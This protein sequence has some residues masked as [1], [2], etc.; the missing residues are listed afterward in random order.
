MVLLQISDETA[1]ARQ[2]T[3]LE[4]FFA[5]TKSLIIRALIIY[6]VSSF[7]RRPS[8]TNEDSAKHGVQSAATNFFQNST[9]FDLHVYISE[10]QLRVDFSDVNSLIWFQKG[11]LYGDW[12][13]GRNGDG[14]VN[15]HTRIHTTEKLQVF[16]FFVIVALYSLV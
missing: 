5:I 10:D 12:V 2:P 16:H 13:S 4:S 3:K 1:T 6:F 8:T 15:H 11:L 14:T 9:K 7:L